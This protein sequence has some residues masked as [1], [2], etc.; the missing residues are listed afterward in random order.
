[1]E[2]PIKILTDLCL[3]SSIWGGKTPGF[4]T[5]ILYHSLFVLY[6]SVDDCIIHISTYAN[7]AIF[8]KNEKETNLKIKQKKIPEKIDAWKMISF[9]SGDKF[10]PIFRVEYLLVSG[11]NE[12]ILEVGIHNH[13][14]SYTSPLG[15][16]TGSVLA[17]PRHSSG[18]WSVKFSP[19]NGQCDEGTGSTLPLFYIICMYT[20][21][22][23][24]SSIL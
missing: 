15:N 14:A 11:R 5:R 22:L 9:L 19:K 6:F 10:L 21:N 8:P 24:M 4:T 18:A 1:M 2:K 20:W 23:W 3:S 13:N 7:K 16:A 17:R 12:P